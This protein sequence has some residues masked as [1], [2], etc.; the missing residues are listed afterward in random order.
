MSFCLS[1]VASSGARVART[2]GSGGSSPRANTAGQRRS[3]PQASEQAGLPRRCSQGQA[4]FPGAV[5][6]RG[7]AAVVGA[8]APVEDGGLDAGGTCPAGE[9]LAD[10]AGLGLLVALG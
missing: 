7:D 3:W 8:P 4:A 10:L 6:Q 9:R 1:T 2:G 5:R